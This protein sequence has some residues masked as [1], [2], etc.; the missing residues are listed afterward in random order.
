MNPQTALFIKKRFQAYYKQNPTLPP[1]GIEHREWGFLMFDP[2]SGMHRH[3]AFG[4]TA[5]MQEYI[6]AMVPAHIYHSA[7]YYEHP[8]AHTMKE[9]NWLGADLIF[10]LDADHL[11]GTA[12]SYR[13]MLEAVK[14]ETLKLTDFLLGDF[15]FA[16]DDLHIAFSGGRGYHVHIKDGRVRTLD[17]AQRREIVDYLNGTGLDIDHIFKKKPVEGDE[18]KGK[19]LVFPSESGG[20]WGRLINRGL[21]KYLTDITRSGDA[22]KTLMN[23]ENIGK[24]KALK[25][26]DSLNDPRQIERLRKGDFDALSSIPATFWERCI[27]HVISQLKV[28]IDEPVTA[29][30]KRL[31]RAASSLHGK[32]GMKVVSLTVDEL[33]DFEPLDDAV[34]FGSDKI[35]INAAR[36]LEVEMKDEKFEVE[37]GINVL[38]EYAAIYVMCRGGAEY[39]GKLA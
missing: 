3:K 10:D 39:E 38:P 21:I 20:G 16:A 35:R 12:G 37:E 26:I 9:K 33:E 7:A 29:D 6:Q 18:K 1:A 34:V 5:E 17:S 27:N 28:H 19:V 13:G 14:R 25:I 15:G 22:K 24:T 11:P 32:S 4:S 36:P 30:I 8:G 2:E 23:F 31:I